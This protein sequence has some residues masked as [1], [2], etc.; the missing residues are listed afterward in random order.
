MAGFEH[1][2]RQLVEG[3]QGA[4]NSAASTVSGPIDA[5]AW[6]LRKAGLPIPENP[7]LGSKW[8]EEKGF[9]RPAEGLAGAIGE[10]IGNSIPIVAA[11]KAPQIAQSL[12][13]G[14]GKLIDEFGPTIT[15]MAENYLDKTG[16]KMNAILVPEHW[17]NL[18]KFP[19]HP[20]GKPYPV[21]ELPTGQRVIGIPRQPG[22]ADHV[23]KLEHYRRGGLPLFEIAPE[24]KE[25]PLANINTI[26][27]PGRR[28]GSFLR[29]FTGRDA[30]GQIKIGD[31]AHLMEQLGT[32]HHEA[33]HG[34]QGVGEMI[35]KGSNPSLYRSRPVI[36]E[37]SQ[38]ISNLHGQIPTPLYT[39]ST[40]RLAEALIS[41]STG[42]EQNMGEMVAR[43]AGDTANT[44]MPSTAHLEHVANA[45]KL[46]F[47][48]FFAQELKGRNQ[49][50]LPVEGFK[51]GWMSVDEFGN[52]ISDLTKKPFAKIVPEY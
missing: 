52:L 25:T 32:L 23:E 30:P 13:K 20:L 29:V 9:T 49:V 1:I 10:G 50:M 44:I 47:G 26:L 16:G 33:T 6:G 21:L 31:Q 19:D 24:I 27:D 14:Q 36:D 2:I 12:I 8:M 17:Q 5:L 45:H 48:T 28:G 41:P 35:G 42:Y 38:G 40:D 4:S 15:R 22:G 11:A 51:Q 34:A 18:Y 43:I 7:M 37:L 46:P 39:K 3:V